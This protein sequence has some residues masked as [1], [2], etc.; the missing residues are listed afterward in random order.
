MNHWQNE[1]L[2]ELH[3]KDLINESK[4]IHIDSPAKR[5]H[6]H[7]PSLVSRTKFNLANWMITKGKKLRGSP[8]AR[9]FSHVHQ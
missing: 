5:P 3:R 4:Q 1:K 9:T 7:R 2:A 6:T 8:E